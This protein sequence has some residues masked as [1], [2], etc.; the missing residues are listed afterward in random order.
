MLPIN[1]SFYT[2]NYMLS[3]EGSCLPVPRDGNK[4]QDRLIIQVHWTMHSY[5]ASRTP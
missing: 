4:V 5:S 2:D 3:R 1:Q